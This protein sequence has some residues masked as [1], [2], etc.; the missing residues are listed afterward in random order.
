MQTTAFRYFIFLAFNAALLFS[1]PYLGIWVHE[2]THA[3]IDLNEGRNVKYISVRTPIGILTKSTDCWMIKFENKYNCESFDK[4]K[5]EGT[6]ALYP[7][8][9]ALAI[10]YGR[11][12]EAEA[13]IAENTF[14]LLSAIG[15]FLNF[16]RVGKMEFEKE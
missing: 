6:K 13:N 4:Y 12:T 1:L 11:N 16:V 3:A 7:Y 2:F 9:L 5:E 8:G 10:P 14:M 15:I